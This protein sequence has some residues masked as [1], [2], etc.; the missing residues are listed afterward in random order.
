MGKIDDMR[1]Q[2]E[3]Q[4]AK[5]QREHDARLR[6]APAPA[7]AARAE[8][9][10]DQPKP[11][12][13]EPEKPEPEKPKSEK[14]EPEKAKSEK[15]KPEKRVAEKAA[16]SSEPIANRNAKADKG[17]KTEGKC[18]G[19]GKVRPLVNGKVGNHQK[20][21]GKMCPGSRKEPA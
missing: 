19:C 20:G 1:R 5:Q 7:P 10:A 14:P 16:A 18:S 12:M 21:F 15:A 17:D 13:S 6:R 11:T 8:R 9:T 3:E 2:R 4:A